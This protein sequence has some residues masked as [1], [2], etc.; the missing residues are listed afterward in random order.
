MNT[1]AYVGNNPLRYVDPLGLDET[2]YLNSSRNKYGERNAFTDFPVN[3]NW[4]GKCW[5]GGAYACNG[6]P[7]GDKP[8]TDSADQCYK[9]HDLCYRTCGNPRDPECVAACDAGLVRDLKMLSDD[10]RKWPQPPRSGTERDSKLYRRG[11]I[12]WFSP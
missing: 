4:G 11:A 6:G 10:P 2:I 5:S 9:D 1:Y 8:P 12:E 7:V 3:G